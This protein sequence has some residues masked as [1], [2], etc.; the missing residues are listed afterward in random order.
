MDDQSHLPHQHA[1]VP[2]GYEPAQEALMRFHQ[3]RINAVETGDRV[4]QQVQVWISET[5]VVSRFVSTKLSPR[6]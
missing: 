5:R 4:V 6:R 2:P 3:E 1:A